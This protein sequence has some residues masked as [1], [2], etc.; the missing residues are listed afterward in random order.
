MKILYFAYG[1]NM[2]TDQ[3]VSRIPSAKPLGRA[4]VHD[5]QVVFNKKSKDGSGKAN[6]V[7]SPG[8]VSWGVLYKIDTQDMEIL[9]SIEG[10]YLRTQV[11]VWMDDET[12]VFA[13]TFASTE[14]TDE[15]VAYEWYK[16]RLVVGA[17]EHRLPMDYVC[18][19]ERLPA[20]TDGSR[21][22]EG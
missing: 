5:R 8:S 14:L 16:Q 2:A 13:E 11:T 7:D 1:S 20:R 22:R 10:G 4:R 15:P 6:L 17:R 12:T 18:Y 9:N 21:S 3:M 19:L